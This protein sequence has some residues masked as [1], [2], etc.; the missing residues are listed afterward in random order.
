MQTQVNV[1]NGV[2][3]LPGC[4][5]TNNMSTIN[6]VMFSLFVFHCIPFL[7]YNFWLQKGSM[8]HDQQIYIRNTPNKKHTPLLHPPPPTHTHKHRSM[9][10]MVYGLFPSIVG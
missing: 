9:L 7:A 10:R 5:Q 3:A 6:I 8:Q 4:C 1:G 2:W